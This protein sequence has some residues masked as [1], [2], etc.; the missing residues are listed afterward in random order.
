MSSRRRRSCRRLGLR[1]AE[2]R[3]RRRLRLR[4]LPRIQREVEQLRAQEE[5]DWLDIQCYCVKGRR[6][7]CTLPA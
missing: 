6:S 2:Q 5:S 7:S 3:Q 1:A 4:L